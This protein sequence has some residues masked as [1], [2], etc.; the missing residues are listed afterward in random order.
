MEIH[1]NFEDF[2]KIENPVV[3]TGTFDGVHVGHLVII[4]R[5]NELAQEINGESV[6][7]TFHPHP[8]KVL[9]PEQSKDLKLIN[10]QEEKKMMLKTTG[11]NHL[12][13]IEFTLDFAKTS[14]QD[15]VNNILLDKLHAKVI[16][17]GFNHHFGHNREGDYSYLY[18]LSKD[19]NFVVE[20]IPQQ[21]IENEAISSTR[22]RKAIAEGHIGRVNAYLNHHYIIKGIVIKDKHDKIEES[23]YS[24]IITEEE[25]LLPPEG[26]YAAKLEQENQILYTMVDIIDDKSKKVFISNL[27]ESHIIHDINSTLYFYKRIRLKEEPESFFNNRT[28]DKSN[29]MELI[30]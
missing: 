20:E 6:L 19:R 5:L 24:I 10:S 29:I 13:I 16:V 3:T 28:I 23:I 15:F 18:K 12:F 1:Y 4:N 17:V 7:I 26:R 9:Y 14:S 22:I 30:Y 25:K 11:L 2:G 8:R 21:D 27:D